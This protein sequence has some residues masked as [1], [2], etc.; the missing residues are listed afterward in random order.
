MNYFIT[1][2]VCR[3]SIL[4]TNNINSAKFRVF[5]SANCEILF[6]KTFCLQMFFPE[7]CSFMLPWKLTIFSLYQWLYAYQ[8]HTAPWPL[9]WFLGHRLKVLSVH[10][11]LDFSPESTFSNNQWTSVKCRVSPFFLRQDIFNTQFDDKIFL[12]IVAPHTHCK[13][14]I[15]LHSIFWWHLGHE[16]YL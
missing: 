12:F 6:W 10:S 2:F 3:L 4:P 11:F 13:I 5:G 1:I 8:D 9:Q 15:S 14:C 16:L 7:G